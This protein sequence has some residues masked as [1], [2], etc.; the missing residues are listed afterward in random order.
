[1]TPPQGVIGAR[2]KPDQLAHLVIGLAIFLVPVTAIGAKGI[3]VGAVLLAVLSLAVTK[4]VRQFK[5]AAPML[6]LWAATAACGWATGVHALSGQYGRD[7][8]ASAAYRLYALL[9][10]GAVTFFAVL[11]GRAIL[12]L[13]VTLSIYAAGCIVQALLDHAL[14]GDNAWKSVFAW[15]VAVLVLAIIQWRRPW[16]PLLALSAV[17]V[18]LDFRS[19]AGLCALAAVLTIVYQPRRDRGTSKARPLRSVLLICAGFWAIL[20]IGTS[21]A[22]GGYLGSEVQQRTEVQTASGHGLLV[23][24]RP[25]WGGT[26]QLA[27]IEPVGYGPGTVPAFQDT[28]AFRA[29]LASLGAATSGEYVDSYLLGGRLEVHSVAGDLWVHFGFLG[30]VLALVF[31]YRIAIGLGSELSKGLTSSAL[32]FLGIIALWDLAFSPMTSNY[33]RVVVAAAALWPLLSQSASDDKKVRPEDADRSTTP[34]ASVR[35]R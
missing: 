32:L 4:E 31:L 5:A 10:L 18:Y 29:G 20:S 27:K 23:G 24:A 6:L 3:S 12:G 35:A 22:A 11:W 14:W 1:M 15:P 34:R 33:A 7:Y 2:S 30:A 19:M 25:E 9:G 8:D 16:W 17:S 26:W 28:N 21:L 13:R